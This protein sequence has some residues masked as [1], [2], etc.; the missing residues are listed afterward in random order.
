MKRLLLVSIALLAPSLLLAQRGPGR[1]PPPFAE[2]TTEGPGASHG[3]SVGIIG[4]TGGLWQP[5]GVEFSMLW[6]LGQHAVTSA[7]ASLS[8]GSF[9]QDQAVYFGRSQGF[10]ASLGVTLRQPIVTL[11]EVGSE[12]APSFIKFETALDAAGSWDINS[13]MPQGK[14]DARVALLAGVSFGSGT[15]LGQSV[16][17]MFGPAAL[18]GRETTTHGEFVLRFRMPSH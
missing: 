4:Y 16:F 6:R 2:D 9:T 8:V 11:A 10:F 3:F 14:T 12:R 7:G 1:R 15:A 18:I 5:S 13:P 17:L